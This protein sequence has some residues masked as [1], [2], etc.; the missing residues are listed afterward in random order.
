MSEKDGL[1]ATSDD[2]PLAVRSRFFYDPP[3]VCLLSVVCCLCL[4][5]ASMF[6]PVLHL[7]VAAIAHFP[8]EGAK[9]WGYFR[10]D[11]ADMP[12]FVA[13]SDSGKG[14]TFTLFADTLFAAV[15][16]LL[17]DLRR[18][19]AEK[20]RDLT[21]VT[22]AFDAAVAET[23][24]AGEA[25]AHCKRRKKDQV[26]A[27]LSGL[28]LKVPYNADTDVGYRPLPYAGKK[29]TNLFDAVIA[30]HERSLQECVSLVLSAVYWLCVTRVVRPQ[31]P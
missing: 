20:P 1:S 15:G 25:S 9:H 5:E 18:D 16:R 2:V 28:G 24:H 3:E 12:A 29:L 4:S 17:R 13:E 31:V 8:A 27:T 23:G 26:A 6:S 10:D 11:P 30:K 14:A 21:S 22:T 7:Q 19:G